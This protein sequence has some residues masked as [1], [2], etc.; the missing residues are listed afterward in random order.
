[1][2]SLVLSLKMH[3]KPMQENGRKYAIENIRRIVQL[4]K[5][6]EDSGFDLSLWSLFS[7]ISLISSEIS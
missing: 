4:Q 5:F 1:M 6:D 7:W 2:R 3:N